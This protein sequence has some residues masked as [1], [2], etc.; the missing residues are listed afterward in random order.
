MTT[1]RVLA[2][3]FDG[4]IW[5]SAGECFETGWRAYKELF[6]SDM[7]GETNRA[8]FLAGRPLARTGHDFFLILR[9]LEGQPDLDLST[10]SP[11]EFLTLR[12]QWAEE[13]AQFN[14]LFYQLRSKYRD[15]DFDAWAS[16]QGA[17]PDMVRLLDR[18]QDRFTGVAI[19]TTKD[20]ASAHALLQ[21][22]GRDW[23]I[24]GKEFSVDKSL[25]IA[26][27]AEQFKVE[28]SEI[29]FID[30]L[31]ENL[32]QVAPTGAQTAMAEWGYNTDELKREAR[33]L[34]YTVLDINGLDAAFG[35]AFGEV[36][37]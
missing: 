28:P 26:G 13:A 33:A 14:T 5:D 31:L 18:W 10:Y 20:A 17:Y 9:L 2:L 4:V 22:V 6:G 23:P 37:A 32:E 34:G 36:P 16:W 11:A 21:S 19:A 12:Q 25:Q 35:K 29:L 1:P 27:I 30:D 24:F 15:E 8:K 7:S 3:D